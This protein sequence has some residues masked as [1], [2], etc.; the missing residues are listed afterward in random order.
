MYFGDDY[1]YNTPVFSTNGQQFLAGNK[2]DTKLSGSCRHAG[3]VFFYCE[4]GFRDNQKEVN[5]TPESE[6][7]R[8]NN[9]I[10]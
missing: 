7:K 1:K 9:R 2:T 3:A 4:F 5:E 6:V 8:I 10:P